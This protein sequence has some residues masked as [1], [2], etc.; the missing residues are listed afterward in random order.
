MEKDNKENALYLLHQVEQLAKGGNNQKQIAGILGFKTTFTLNNR[1]VKASQISGRPVPP[2]KPDRMLKKGLRPVK[3][4]EV[5]RRGKGDAFDVNV[6]Q[7]PLLR[8]G[9]EP[10]DIPDPRGVSLI[11]V[12]G[13]SVEQIGSRETDKFNNDEIG[14]EVMKDLWKEIVK[15]GVFVEAV[16]EDNNQRVFE[17]LFDHRIAYDDFYNP[18]NGKT[19]YKISKEAHEYLLGRGVA[20][21]VVEVR[22]IGDLSL[23]ERNRIKKYHKAQQGNRQQDVLNRLR[24][25]YGS[26]V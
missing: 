5:K 12:M 26:N 17:E 15:K 1:L 4:V 18:A 21:E 9:L 19:V 6:P 14:N 7:E 16:D 2:F 11:S 3:F 10:L 25:E 22:N 8:A 24:A 13:Q 20:I 23:E